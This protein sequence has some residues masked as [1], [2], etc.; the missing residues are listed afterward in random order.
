M[1]PVTKGVMQ[2]ICLDVFQ[3]HLLIV[4]LLAQTADALWFYGLL[5]CTAACRYSFCLILVVCFCDYF[6]IYAF[7][8]TLKVVKKRATKL[9]VLEHFLPSESSMYVLSHE[10]N[11]YI[12][13]IEMSCWKWPNSN[14]RHWQL[15]V[16]WQGRFTVSQPWIESR[17][18]SS[19]MHW[20]LTQSI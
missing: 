11:G 3:K 7:Q 14:S 1:F 6:C 16:A 9:C 12:D 17:G 20:S 19:M 10:V 2:L 13:V 4:H 15:Y 18:L 8:L 5:L